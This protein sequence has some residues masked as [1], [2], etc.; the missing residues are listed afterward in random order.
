MQCTDVE[1]KR[2]K[3]PLDEEA[4]RK[5]MRSLQRAMQ[6]ESQ[7]FEEEELRR[8]MEQEER[9]RQQRESEAH[10]KAAAEEER[11]RKERERDEVRRKA[12]ANTAQKEAGEAWWL[13]Y[14]NKGAGNKEREI[15][16]LKARLA[17]FQKIAESSTAE[18]EREN[19]MRLAAQAQDKLDTLMTAEP[20]DDDAMDDA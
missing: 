6:D 5:K 10:A 20:N 9:L 15:A 19:A 7:L 2:F 18:G 16:K 11:E 4:V 14:Q 17:R 3:V 1:L 8:R 13:Q 12:A